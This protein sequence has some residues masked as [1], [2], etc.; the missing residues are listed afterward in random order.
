MIVL[1]SSLVKKIKFGADIFIIFRGYSP[2]I[3]R[4]SEE[5]AIPESLG[6]LEIEVFVGAPAHEGWP[7]TIF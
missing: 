6:H 7:D 2:H 4:N 5:M 3:E 1:G